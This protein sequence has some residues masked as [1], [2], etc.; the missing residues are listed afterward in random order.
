MAVTLETAYSALKTSQ[1]FSAEEQLKHLLKIDPE[2]IEARTGLLSAQYGLGK[3]CEVVSGI[4]Y[5][6]VIDSV[7]GL[8]LSW[9]LTSLYQT[10]N[11]DRIEV[12]GDRIKEYYKHPELLVLL[13]FCLKQAGHHDLALQI[14]SNTA[15]SYPYLTVIHFLDLLSA[16]NPDAD[17]QWLRM[18]V[19]EVYNI[20]TEIGINP[21]WLNYQLL[22]FSPSMDVFHQIVGTPAKPVTGRVLQYNSLLKGRF[23]ELCD[24]CEKQLLQTKP[25]VKKDFEPQIA[26]CLLRIRSLL[27][28]GRIK[29]YLSVISAAKEKFAAGVSDPIQVISTGRAGTMTLYDMLC[30]TR[31]FQPFHSFYLQ[32]LPGDRNEFLTRLRTENLDDDYLEKIVEQY[33]QIR[34]S[35]LVY[36]YSNS[37]IPVIVSHWD[38]IFALINLAIFP[39]MKLLFLDRD[40][41]SVAGSM[42]GKMQWAYNQ[43]MDVNY[44]LEADRFNYYVDTEKPL[45]D[46]VAWYQFITE[47]LAQ[48]LSDHC[49]AGNYAHIQANGLFKRQ[50]DTV[51][52][53]R[54]FFDCSELGTDQINSAYEVPKNQKNER[55]QLGPDWVHAEIAKTNECY[56][57]YYV[58]K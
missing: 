23:R 19:H 38:S 46:H 47:S 45:S 49:V 50:P 12:F 11:A 32:T 48:S 2:N 55:I 20:S 24:P 22:R 31:T 44:C 42:I 56:Q 33:L 26:K 58:G 54:D 1:F 57:G 37:K 29:D 27:T 30:E 17:G 8:Q 13:V 18:A 10:G 21:D 3:R 35:E 43:L 36:A 16:D 14:V 5:P 7:G 15:N 40:V 34:V 28:K 53:L 9:F 52:L 39:E 6:G 41:T 25:V 51:N 4:E